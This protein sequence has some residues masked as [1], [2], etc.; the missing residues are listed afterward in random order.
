MKYE[1]L[2]PPQLAGVVF[3]TTASVTDAA[4]RRPFIIKA[5]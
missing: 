1:N 5:P 3:F 2:Y 4:S